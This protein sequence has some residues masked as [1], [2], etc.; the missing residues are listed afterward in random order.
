MINEIARQRILAADALGT[1]RATGE[2]PLTNDIKVAAGAHQLAADLLQS[3]LLLLFPDLDADPVLGAINEAE[4]CLLSS[5][6][7]EDQV[8]E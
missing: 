5:Q 6:S 4:R 3:Y 1:V 8:V 7:D 2:N